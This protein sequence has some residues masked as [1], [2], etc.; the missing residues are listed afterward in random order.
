MS[1]KSKKIR[2]ALLFGGKSA[3]HDVSIMSARNIYQAL[4][5]EKYIITPIGITREGKWLPLRDTILD[6]LPV[7]IETTL[8]KK[9]APSALFSSNQNQ[10]LFLR[11]DTQEKNLDVIFPVLHGPFGEDGSIQ[12]TCKMFGIPFVGPSILGSSVSMDKDVMKRLLRE[13]GIPVAKALVL[14]QLEAQPD[15]SLVQSILGEVVF[16]KPANLGSSVG[17]SRVTN[18]REYQQALDKAFTY[19]MKLLIEEAIEGREIE[20]SVLGNEY[21][22]ASIAGEITTDRAKHGFYSYE[23]K[24]LDEKGAAMAIPANIT[25]KQMQEVRTLAVKVFQT[26]CCEGM[27]RVDFFLKK[28]G[29]FVVNEINTIPGFT[30]ISMYPKLWEASGLRYSELIDTLINL[31]LQRFE[32]DQKLKTTVEK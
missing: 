21:P 1:T 4:D 3:E 8:A 23:A 5:K 16:V 10:H 26:L 18:E 29:S 27:G 25:L 7:Q 2:I 12:G 24:Y 11:P 32:R 22:Q 6:D 31:A 15:F 19:D 30:S 9:T 20:C 13:A 17:V 14:R 28:D